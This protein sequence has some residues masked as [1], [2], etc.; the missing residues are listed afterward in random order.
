MTDWDRFQ[1]VPQ[2]RG[3]VVEPSESRFRQLDIGDLDQHALQNGF[4]PDWRRTDGAREQTRRDALA[5]HTGDL[6]VFAYGS[7][8]W[9]PG[10]HFTDLRLATVEGFHRSFCLKSEL[11]RGSPEKP[12]LMAGLDQGG[13]CHGLAFQIAADLVDAETMIIWMREMLL[14]SYVPTF[15]P[16]RLDDGD[17]SALT[18]VVDR[19]IARYVGGVSDDAAARMICTG[20]GRLGRSF[21]YL[22]NLVQQM[23]LL[24]IDDP[25]TLSLH[26][27]CL[28]LLSSA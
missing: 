24:N 26:A 23:R 19:S 10:F 22:D 11:G 4:G 3:K 7:L 1:H 16:V 8:M 21:D 18:F 14:D 12:G 15:V 27:R 13:T 28:S 6:W 20:E 17:A 5:Q 2:L 9:D 25:R